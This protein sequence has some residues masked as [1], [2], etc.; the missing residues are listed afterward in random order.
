[1]SATKKVSDRMTKKELIEVIKTQREELE[2]EKAR[3]GVDRKTELKLVKE[4]E[5][6]KKATDTSVEDIIKTF[7]VQINGALS[8]FEGQLLE[9]KDRLDQIQE[10]IGIEEKRLQDVYQIA[11][12]SDTL[13]VLLRAHDKEKQEH[14]EI[15]KNMRLQWQK[16]QQEH[17]DA[18]KESDALTKKEWAR[19]LEE[20]TYDWKQKLAREKDLFIEEKK[21]KQ[22]ELKELEDITN[23]SLAKRES[24]VTAQEE[25]IAELR[26]KVEKIDEN[27]Q[28]AIE[29][30]VAKALKSE[31]TSRH[32]EVTS[33]KRDHEATIKVLEASQ[34]SLTDRVNNLDVQNRDLNTKL[35]TA[36]AEMRVLAQKTIEASAQAKVYVTNESKGNASGK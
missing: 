36:Y 28:A 17:A 12:Q 31:K 6:V 32:F 8:G 25:D 13:E 18:I 1:M 14:A 33:L 11:H 7:R 16:E 23:D 26:A 9:K 24:A 21:L 4:K 2:D 27:K 10:A 5:T 15:V 34:E 19:K 3:N 30:A 35:E 29:E 20:H 22:R